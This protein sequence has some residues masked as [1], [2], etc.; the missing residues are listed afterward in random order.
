MLRMYRYSESDHEFIMVDGRHVDIPRFRKRSDV[1]ALCMLHEVEGI[2]ILDEAEGAD[3]SLEY[4]AADGSRTMPPLEVQ[5]CS[6]AFADLLGIKPF[7][8][9][10]YTFAADDGAHDAM[11]MSHLGECK[12]V[13]LDRAAKAGSTLCEGEVEI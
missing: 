2:A 6:V 7:H 3:Y 5:R 9:Q 13:K 11:I 8:T 4:H 1:H 10:N 12:V